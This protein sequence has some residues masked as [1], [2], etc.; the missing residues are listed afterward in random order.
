ML[1]RLA[2]RITII[3]VAPPVV[4]WT[5]FAELTW[6]LGWSVLLAWEATADEIEAV[7]QAWKA[8]NE[9]MEI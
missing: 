1:T 7:R 8:I 5:F 2:T 4:V 3:L 6:E 9:D